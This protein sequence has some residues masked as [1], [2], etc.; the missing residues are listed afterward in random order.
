[1]GILRQAHDND[2]NLLHGE[3]SFA[4][5][6][7]EGTSSADGVNAYNFTLRTAH[8][9]GTLTKRLFL[10]EGHTAIYL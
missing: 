3:P 2:R 5:W 7:L 1:M 9:P 4:I 6:Q 10:V 8:P